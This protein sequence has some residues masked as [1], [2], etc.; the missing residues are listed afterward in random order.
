M[1]RHMWWIEVRK[2]V[3]APGALGACM[4]ARLIGTS[5]SGRRGASSASSSSSRTW[6]TRCLRTA[7]AASSTWK[8]VSRPAGRP[9]CGSLTLPNPPGYFTRYYRE[10]TAAR[11]SEIKALV[12]AGQLTFANG[13][14][15]MADEAATTLSD[16]LDMT[17]RGHLFLQETFG[18]SP[19]LGW[20][21]DP[22]GHSMEQAGALG[23][24]FGYEG[25]V[26][27]RAHYKDLAQRV[28]SQTLE[29]RWGEQKGSGHSFL[30]M[31]YGTGNYGPDGRNQKWDWNTDQSSTPI[32]DDP[33]LDGY[34][35][36][37]IAASFADTACQYSAAP[38]RRPCWNSAWW[39]QEASREDLSGSRAQAPR[40]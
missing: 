21:I 18:Y 32:V 35:V 37:T 3:K 8:W 14:W 11:Q 40:A 13:G 9:S 27:G 19:R 12:A 16:Q 24:G 5:S 26:I 20:Q 6:S 34:N 31:I 2:S 36:D 30:G 15:C 28:A 17:A 33:L 1:P 25:V 10:Q 7:L 22:F 4:V 29:F 39:I 23:V 38:R